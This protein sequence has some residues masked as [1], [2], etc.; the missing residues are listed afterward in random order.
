[1]HHAYRDR[2]VSN[3]RTRNDTLLKRRPDV[4]LFTGVAASAVALLTLAEFFVKLSVGTRP[5]LDNSSALIAFIQ[6]TTTQTLVVVLLDT[7][8]MTALIIF[9]ASFRQLIVRKRPA[10]TWITDLAF[11]AGLVF[12]A[13]TLVGDSMDAGTALDAMN[14]HG[15]AS[16]LRALTE[17]HMLIFGPI[18][19]ILTALVT[20]IFGY[21]TYVT[22]VVPLWTARLAYIVALLNIAVVPAI[23]G[24]TDPNSFLSAGGTG[25]ALL[26][27]FPFLL[28]VVSVGVVTIKHDPHYTKDTGIRRGFF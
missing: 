12:V 10:I 3:I 20:A 21:T 6:H 9:F 25:V 1:M 22:K 19:C 13:V 16:V 24:G 4:R 5:D 28:W 11:G 27:T 23:F 7:V 15:D 26:A 8:L 2:L 14:A 17:G 18:G